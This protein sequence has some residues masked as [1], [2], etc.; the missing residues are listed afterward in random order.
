MAILII[1]GALAIVGLG[2]AVYN[3]CRPTPMQSL[4]PRTWQPTVAAP[5][6][7]PVA[8]QDNEVPSESQDQ[9]VQSMPDQG[10]TDLS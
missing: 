3:L 7:Q 4:S 1:I 6:A 8:T 2:L 5:P 9:A 10:H